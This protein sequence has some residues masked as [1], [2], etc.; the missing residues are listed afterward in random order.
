MINKKK[1]PISI[2]SRKNKGRKLQ[3]LVAKKLSEITGLSYGKDELIASREM[4]QSGID[5]R[6]IGEAKKLIPWSIECKWQEIWKI[7][8]WTK[9]AKI[10]QLENTDWLLVVK[11][12]NVD[13]IVILDMEVFFNLIKKLLEKK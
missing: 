5:I 9:Q 12:N 6:L 11:K 2:A 7:L 1:K 3:Q 8:Q 13:P 4:G 10:N